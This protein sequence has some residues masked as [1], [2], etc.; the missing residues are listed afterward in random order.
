MTILGV[1]SYYVYKNK[2]RS[3]IKKMCVYIYIKLTFSI[4]ICLQPAFFLMLAYY[5]IIIL[6]HL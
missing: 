5:F 1:K 6:T 3:Q 2:K 4:C